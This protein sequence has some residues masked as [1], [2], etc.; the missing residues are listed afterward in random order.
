PGGKFGFGDRAK[1][2]A[3]FESLPERTANQGVERGIFNLTKQ[4]FEQV[5]EELS[6]PV[7]ISTKGMTPEAIVASLKEGLTIPLEIDAS[8]RAALRAAIPLNGELHGLSTGTAIAIAL[9]P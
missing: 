2:Q 6:A 9:R 7:T 5:Y 1:L 4:Q 3:Y 8:A